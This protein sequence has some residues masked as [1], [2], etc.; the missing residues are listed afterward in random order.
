MAKK[1]SSFPIKLLVALL[2]CIISST[3]I[4]A[5]RSNVWCEGG[6]V[7]FRPCY[8]RAIDGTC[9]R[10]QGGIYVLGRMGQGYQ[11]M[12]LDKSEK[13]FCQYEAPTGDNDIPAYARPYDWQRAPCPL[14][15]P[16]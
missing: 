10:A 5:C 1:I 9:Y 13:N 6:G 4:G 2:A 14:G 12:T 15:I 8:S 16:N 11:Q 3:S 7:S